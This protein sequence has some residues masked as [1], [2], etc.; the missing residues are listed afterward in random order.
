MVSAPWLGKSLVEDNFINEQ[1]T[2]ERGHLFNVA[3][4]PAST[5][6]DLE[7]GNPINLCVV[8]MKSCALTVGSGS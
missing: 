3:I 7:G 8:L 6:M 2:A 4:K 5:V 1:H